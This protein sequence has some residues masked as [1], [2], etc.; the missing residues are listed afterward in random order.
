M[1]KISDEVR[2]F[3]ENTMKNRRVKLTTGKKN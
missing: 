2:K 3:I 1:N